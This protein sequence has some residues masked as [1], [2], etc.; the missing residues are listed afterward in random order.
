MTPDEFYNAI[1]ELNWTMRAVARQLG[2]SLD[3]VLRWSHGRQRVPQPVAD[4][5]T[6]LTAAH[7]LFSPPDW[8]KQP[9]GE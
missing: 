7:R 2:C 8:R 5:L 1:A 3:T 4:W 6:A 9:R